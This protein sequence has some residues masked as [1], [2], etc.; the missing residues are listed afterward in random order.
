MKK[1]KLLYLSLGAGL[2]GPL[3][4]IDPL[5]VNALCDNGCDIT[6]RDWGRHSDNESFIQK[7]FGRFADL[8]KILVELH[9][10]N[11]EILYIGTTLDEYALARDV[12]LLLLSRRFRAKKVL[13]MHG[14]KTKKLL[15]PGHFLYKFFTRILVRYADA[16]LLL[17]NDEIADW[18]AFQPHGK[19]FRIDNPFVASDQSDDSDFK[20]KSK[21]YEK[22]NLLFVGRLIREKGIFDLIKAMPAIL[23]QVNCQLIIAG[24]GG[25]AEAIC[26]LIKELNLSQYVSL[27]GYQNSE[28]LSK[29]YKSSSIFILPTYFGEGFPTAIAEA[30]SYS[31]PIVTTEIRGTRDHLIDGINC[32]YVKPKD[33]EGISDAIVR[34][35]KNP[36]LSIKMG[37]VNK[38][39][40][41]V[42]LPS[43]VVTSYLDVFNQILSSE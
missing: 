2:R 27:L 4:K 24:S 16:I 6:K 12:P 8:Q 20:K 13:M 42:F 43:N 39:K 34:L 30:M 21:Q 33:P 38:T 36:D 7:V 40:V 28:N 26:Q 32:L 29:L 41:K 37:R 22:P 15:E 23:K 3:P 11:P 18:K 14:S 1:H 25:E 5:L 19:Y 31:L 17:S 35:L 9:R 10:L